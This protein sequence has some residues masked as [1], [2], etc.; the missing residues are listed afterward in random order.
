MWA[1]VWKDPA[2]AKDYLAY[3][4]RHDHGNVLGAML[5]SWYGADSFL[6]AFEG[7]S[8]CKEQSLGEVKVYNLL[9]AIK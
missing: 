4:A 2:A 8:G 5:T 3:A 1:C 7:K 9:K 6:D